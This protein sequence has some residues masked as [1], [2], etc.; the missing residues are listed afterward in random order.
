LANATHDLLTV[1]DLID[2]KNCVTDFK[3]AKKSKPESEVHIST[4]LTIYAAAR[5]VDAG[6]LPSEVRLDVLVKTKIAKR[7]LL[8]STR[9]EADLQV[10]ANRINVTLGAINAGSFPPCPPGSWNCSS[11]W[12][13][14][15]N[16][17]PYVNSERRAATEG[18]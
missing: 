12:C 17:C 9:T 15:F 4:Q 3:T 2:T 6:C 11:R 13:G 18:E 8:R 5:M 14:Y 10:L 7:Q 16:T 1:T